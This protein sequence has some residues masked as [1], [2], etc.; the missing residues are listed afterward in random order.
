[1]SVACYPAWPLCAG[2]QAAGQGADDA[3]VGASTPSRAH[4]DDWHFTT[5]VG[6]GVLVAP[7]VIGFGAN[8]TPVA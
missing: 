3:G 1:M 6:T 2:D 8:K 5:R 4:Y 7:S